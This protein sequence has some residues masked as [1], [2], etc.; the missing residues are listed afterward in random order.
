MWN[1]NTTGTYSALDKNA[2]IVWIYALMESCKINLVPTVVKKEQ[3]DIQ[4][5]GLDA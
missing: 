2:Y 5:T 1:I 4:A 3:N